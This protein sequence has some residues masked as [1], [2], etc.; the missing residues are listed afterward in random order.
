MHAVEVARVSWGAFRSRV[1][2]V[3][4]SLSF[5]YRYG[6]VERLVIV[7]PNKWRIGAENGGQL[8]LLGSQFE[9]LEFP[10]AMAAE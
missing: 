1:I 9:T 4:A 10:K 5:L 7:N 2:G 3:V 8:T 6:Q